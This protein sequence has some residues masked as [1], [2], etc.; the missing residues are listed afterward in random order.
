M[1]LKTGTWVVVADGGR[2]ILLVNIGTAARPELKARQ[3]WDLENPR[4]SEQGRDRPP[5]A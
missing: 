1:K 2:G 5:R 4:T 3:V